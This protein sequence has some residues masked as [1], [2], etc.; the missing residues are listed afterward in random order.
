MKQ[1]ASR[2]GAAGLRAKDQGHYE[3]HGEFVNG[4][5]FRK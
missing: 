5:I 1:A 4:V 3:W 2:A